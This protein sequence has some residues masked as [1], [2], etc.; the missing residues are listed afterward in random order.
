MASTTVLSPVKSNSTLLNALGVLPGVLLLA[1][2]G[3]TGKFL[4]HFLNPYAKTHPWAFPNIEYVLWAI[5]IGL[6]IA[7]TVGVPKV[8]QA[9]VATY[10]FWLKLGIVLLGARFVLADIQKL[11]GISLALV[12]ER[13][14]RGGDGRAHS[15]LIGAAASLCSGVQNGRS[16]CSCRK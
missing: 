7:N 11:G 3:Y 10:E 8:F 9:G 12:T 1:A 14:R 15:R 6:V 4:E 16:E 5:L 13:V 2:I